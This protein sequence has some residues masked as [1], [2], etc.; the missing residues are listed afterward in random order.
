MSRS[1]YAV[2]TLSPAA[3]IPPCS[4]SWQASQ[5]PAKALSHAE[6][7]RAPCCRH[8]QQRRPPTLA[9][10]A[11]SHRVLDRARRLRH[12]RP[13]TGRRL[14]LD[15]AIPRRRSSSTVAPSLAPRN[16]NTL[17]PS[18]KGPDSAGESSNAFARTKWPNLDSASPI[19][20]IQQGTAR[21]NFTTKSKPDGSQSQNHTSPSV[22]IGP[23]ISTTSFPN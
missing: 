10:P 14:H 9:I 8:P 5:A 3:I 4:S 16:A 22:P 13:A 18:P 7:A 17:S 21:P 12:R 11:R 6:L 2:L 20:P 19:Q 23:S 1:F 15:D